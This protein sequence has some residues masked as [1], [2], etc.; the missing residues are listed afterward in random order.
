MGERTRLLL[1]GA[2]GHAKVILDG[3]LRLPE[4][5]V[6]GLLDDN[7]ALRGKEIWGVPILGGFPEL[8]RQ[9][10]KRVRL[11]LAVGANDARK[12]LAERIA[13]LGFSFATVVHPS[14]EIGRGVAIG[15]GTVVM[16]QA[17]VNANTTLGQH[18]IVNTGATIDHDG[19]MGDFVHVSPGAHLAGE[20]KVGPLALVGVGASVI[21]RITIGEGAIVGAGAVVIKDV[22][23]WVVVAGVPA[24]VIRDLRPAESR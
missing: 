21:P 22:P 12:C 18:V 13:A 11:L 7:G 10:P 15:P 8:T 14:A 6:V 23:P 1:Y 24:H 5:E 4:V 19:V 9:D 17:A 20:V 16:P 3:A 2:S